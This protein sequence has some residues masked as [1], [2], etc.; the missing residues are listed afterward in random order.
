MTETGLG[1]WIQ[2]IR[3]ENLRKYEG[4]KESRSWR[5]REYLHGPTNAAVILLPTLGCRWGR[6]VGCS[7]CGYVYDAPRE[8]TQE[9]VLSEFRRALEEVQGVPY[10]KIFTSGSFFDPSELSEE[11]QKEIASA[12]ASLG[13]VERVQVESRPEFL[14]RAAL[15]RMKEAL[16]AEL[17]VGIGLETARDRIREECVHK[18]FTRAAF[19][20]ALRICRQTE[21]PVKA[22]LL[23]KPPFLTEREALQDAVWSTL[24]ARKMGVSRVSLNP[25]NVQ[26]GTLVEFLWRRREYRPP[27]L[28]SALEVLRRAKRE[29]D[30]PLLCHPTAA[31][32]AR[33]PHN[34]GSCDREVAEALREFSTTQDAA[35][36]EGLECECRGEWERILEVEGFF[37]GPMV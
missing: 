3:E 26:R 31:G 36:L 33:G 37:Q 25:M 32:K 20:R 2:R 27:W 7:M 12:I 6:E 11:S 30:I 15:E 8:I 18:G 16:G 17:E 21:V 5:E 22:Y 23:L 13:G 28:W 19:Q 9:E 10:L 1:R 24:E 35:L 29:V 34:C 14:S 4:R